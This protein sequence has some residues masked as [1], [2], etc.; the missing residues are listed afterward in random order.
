MSDR[1]QPWMKWYPADW[2]ADPCLRMCSLA[3]RG[4]WMELLGFMHE[5]EPYGHLV[6]GGRAP[7]VPQ[8]AA[9]VGVDAK[10]VTAA[11]AE[12]DGA[13]VCSRDAEGRIVSRR[14]VRDKAKAE[15]AA[16]NGRAGG[17]PNLLAPDLLPQEGRPSRMKRRDNPTKVEAVWAASG[18]IC[19]DCN[20]TMQR[21]RPNASDAFTI[22]HIIPIARGGTNAEDNLRGVCRA[23][24]LAKGVNPLRSDAVNPP[25]PSADKAQKPEARDPSSLRSDGP[26]AAPPA[27]DVRT[28]LFT[29]GLARL[30]R[31]TGK[32]DKSARSLLGHFLARAAEDAALVGRLLFE[33]EQHAKADPVAWIEGKI[34]AAMGRA[35]GR[36]RTG[37]TDGIGEALRRMAG[38][39]LFHG[40]TVDGR[41]EEVVL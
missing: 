36:G 13:G 30:K 27:V 19:G 1:R 12:L 2:R 25:R 33:A 41:A 38:P 34:N 7:T 18:G 17:N 6:I 11:L 15:A 37:P 9:L 31:I 16:V 39:P 4:L 40:A 35:P 22:D 8:I 23:C 10:T 32:P 20:V 24:N 14:M 21:E 5:A 29:E 28:A 26:P 3:A